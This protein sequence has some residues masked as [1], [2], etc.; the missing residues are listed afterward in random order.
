LDLIFIFLFDGC[1]SDEVAY[2]NLQTIEIIKYRLRAPANLNLI[3]EQGYDYYVGKIEGLE[4]TL[5]FDYGTYTS[6]GKN[7]SDEDLFSV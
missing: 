6:P 2:E 1:D 4:I 3:E 7:I 5:F